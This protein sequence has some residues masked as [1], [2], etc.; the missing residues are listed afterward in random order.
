MPTAA[1]SSAAASLPIAGS[2]FN[3]N[4]AQYSGGAISISGGEAEIDDTIFNGNI[5][6]GDAGY[7][8]GA[9]YIQPNGNL[10]R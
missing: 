8:G 7:G 1:R 9:I 5:A 10:R 4:I 2:V 6:S 3:G